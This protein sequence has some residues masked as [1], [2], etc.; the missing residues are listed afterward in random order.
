MLK[1]REM[2]KWKNVT[3]DMMSEEELGE[4]DTFIRHRPSWRSQTFNKFIKKLDRRFKSKH[5]S[6]SLAKPRSYGTPHN[7]SAPC[8]ISSWIKSNDTESQSHD[9]LTPTRPGEETCESDSDE[10]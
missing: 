8:S 1:A 5:A 2:D 4:E 6:K 7:K 9:C 3:P 10:Q